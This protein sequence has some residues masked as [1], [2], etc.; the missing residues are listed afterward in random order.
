[1][2]II[3]YCNKHFCNYSFH[4]L[5]WT[6][7]AFFLLVCI[8]GGILSHVNLD[9]Y[10]TIIWHILFFAPTVYIP[11][12]ITG[13]LLILKFLLNKEKSDIS[14][15]IS[16][17]YIEHNT[18]YKYFITFSNLICWL[19]IILFL[20]LC[21]YIIYINI[22]PALLIFITYC[23]PIL[24]LMVIAYNIAKKRFLY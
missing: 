20:L 22:Q 21:P 1:M 16:N 12:I 10:Q 19:V 7:W 14:F 3:D 18:I 5:A 17:K 13:I 15:R 24:V 9:Y 4:F 6:F 23:C 8:L 11:I 2:K